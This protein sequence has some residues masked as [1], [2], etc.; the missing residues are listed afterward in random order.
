MRYGNEASCPQKGKNCCR[1]TQMQETRKRR[2]ATVDERMK[3]LLAM[4]EGLTS[5]KLMVE[6]QIRDL[7]GRIKDRNEKRKSLGDH[8][9]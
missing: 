9:Q 1:L 6:K 3:S 8:D 7:D 5:K 2:E 4:R